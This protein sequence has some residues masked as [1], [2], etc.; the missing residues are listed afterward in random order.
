VYHGITLT[1][2]PSQP[3]PYR[4]VQ[5]ILELATEHGTAV[6][7]EA[8]AK[9]DL[10]FFTYKLLEKRQTLRECHRR[11]P[12]NA[13]VAYHY[14]SAAAIPT[15]RTVG[16]LSQKD[17]QGNAA[18]A[19]KTTFHGAV[20]GDGACMGHPFKFEGYARLPRGEEGRTAGVQCTGHTAPCVQLPSRWVCTDDTRVGCRHLY[21]GQP[22]RLHGVWR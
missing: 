15:I 1:S 21:R 3:M 7:V 9:D 6:G 11:P 8:L 12:T 14:T 4:F 19:D 16:L 17:R 10:F 5:Q 20:Y 2:I 18:V 22:L 13:T